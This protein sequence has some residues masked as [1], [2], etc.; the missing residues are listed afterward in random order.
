MKRVAAV[1]RDRVLVRSRELA[2]RDADR[3]A[4]AVE[5]R[6]IQIPLRRVLRRRDEIRRPALLVDAG[7]RDD[8]DVAARD[9]RLAP[10]ARD[11]VDVLPAVLLRRDEEFGAVADRARFRQPAESDRDERIVAIAPHLPGRAG[12]RV[13][14]QIVV[15]VLQS[16]E[17][18]NQ[19]GSRIGPLQPRDVVLARIAGQLQPGDAAAFRVDDARADR[20]VRRARQRIRHAHG[21]RDKVPSADTGRA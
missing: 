18:L 9:E 21:E 4:A 5:R 11:A 17:L 7:E 8:V 6:A 3:L 10:V 14:E 16:I 13:G 19:D 20:G 1:R 12:C 2:R 15:G